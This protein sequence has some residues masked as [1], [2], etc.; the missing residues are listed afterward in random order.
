MVCSIGRTFLAAALATR[1]GEKLVLRVHSTVLL[2]QYIGH[3]KNNKNFP[4]V[5]S[6]MELQCQMVRYGEKVVTTGSARQAP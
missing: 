2:L 5:V 6:W 1:G 3:L 4:K